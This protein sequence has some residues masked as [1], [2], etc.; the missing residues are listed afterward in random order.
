MKQHKTTD[1]LIIGSGMAGLSLAALL[2]QAGFDVAVVDRED[3]AAM[4]KADYDLRTIALS[5]GSRDILVPLGIWDRMVRHAAPIKTIDVQEGHDPFLLNFDAGQVDA[6]AF[7]WIFPNYIV[8]G[9][10]Y[11]TALKSGVTFVQ[12]SLKNITHAEDSVTALLQDGEEIS[13]RLLIGA[14]GRH[15]RVR[16]LIGV[17]GVSLPYHQAAWVGMVEHELPH[18]GLAVERFYDTGPFAILPFVDSKDG[19]HSSAIVWTQELPK[20]KT[21][22]QLPDL[23]TLTSELEP[24][25]DERYGRIQA[26]GKWA[27]YPLSLYHAKQFIADR[28]VLISDAAHAMHPIAGQGLNLGMRDVGLL[29][30]MLGEARDKDE[31]IGSALVLEAYQTARRFD[32]FALMAATDVLNRLF[33]VKLRPVRW[34]RSAGL[35]LVNRIPPLKG[36]F[37]RTAMGK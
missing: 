33:G 35:G 1:I 4:A 17:D 6:E 12:G 22:L 24:L 19:L 16:D 26:V 23:A 5:V 11:E 27:S 3:P 15:S 36:F 8:R 21:N 37:M 7:G 32:V 13:A 30:R 29:A 25:F 18:H 2:A 20:G 34:L 14:D 10:L 28:V 31:D 9:T